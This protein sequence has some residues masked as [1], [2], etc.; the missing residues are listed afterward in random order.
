MLALGKFSGKGNIEK[1]VETLRL[2]KVATGKDS[3]DEEIRDVLT[4]FDLE[5]TDAEVSEVKKLLAK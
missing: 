1:S 4:T 5:G 2:Y 3:T